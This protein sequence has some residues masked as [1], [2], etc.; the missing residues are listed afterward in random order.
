MSSRLFR[1][2]TMIPVPADHR[3]VVESARRAEALGYDVL[4]IPDHLPQA[5]A[6]LPTLVAV[7]GATSRI[8]IGTHVLNN[9]LRHPAVLAQDLATI[10]VLSGGRLEIG[11]GAGWNRPEYEQAGISYDP[12]GRRVSRMEE[13]IKVLKGLFADAP[14]SFAGE[15][16]QITEMSGSPKPVQRPHPPFMVGGGGRRV[17]SIGGREAQI[18][19]LAPR[20]A[21]P[22]RPDVLGC[23]AEGTLEKVGWIRAAAGGRADEVEISTYPPLTP[24]TIT[25]DRR[26]AAREV[27]GQ[28]KALFG[29][30]LS[31]DDVLGSP[32]IFL[33]TVDELVEKCLELRERFGITNVNVRG[34]MEEFAPVME[35]L[36][37]K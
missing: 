1:F 30:E 2:T 24:V 21:A 37:G 4:V 12:I 33:G 11:I 29:L 34:A 14:F 8:R 16:Y 19:G 31:E 3:G 22:D 13:S 32:H 36:A 25:G 23:L 7:A 10:D 28:L 26:A 15:F 18:V 27:A 9:D 35:R 6:P 5:L 20:L 17:L